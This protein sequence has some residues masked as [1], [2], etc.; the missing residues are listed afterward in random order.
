M[1]RKYLLQ[2]DGHTYS[3]CGFTSRGCGNLVICN[4]HV[5]SLVSRHEATGGPVQT[6]RL[7]RAE[8]SEMV[9]RP[10][11]PRQAQYTEKVL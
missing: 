10:S 11:E 3:Y 9:S 4:C 6:G 1:I 8:N 2:R 7:G 5:L